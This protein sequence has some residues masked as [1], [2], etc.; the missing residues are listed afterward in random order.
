MGKM[1]ALT[2]L[3]SEIFSISLKC[4]PTKAIELRDKF[5]YI[6]GAYHL[7]KTHWNS[8]NC[9]FAPT[10]QVKE[11]TDHSFQLVVAGLPKK[12]KLEFDNLAINS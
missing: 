2:S 4:E 9:N 10:Q 7:N 8:V 12:I 5:N 1:F 6:V 11:L 3:A